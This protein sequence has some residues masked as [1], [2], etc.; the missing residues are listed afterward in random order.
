MDLYFVIV[1][2]VRLFWCLKGSACSVFLINMTRQKAEVSFNICIIK[3]KKELQ[4]LYFLDFIS[5]SKVN[6]CVFAIHF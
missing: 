1:D 4:Q 3:K 2:V 5:T 6:D